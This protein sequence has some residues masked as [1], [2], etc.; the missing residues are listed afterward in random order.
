[1][2]REIH[3]IGIRL[4]FTDRTTIHR[5]GKM[6]SLPSDK[7]FPRNQGTVLHGLYFESANRFLFFGLE[8]R[9]LLQILFLSIKDS[10]IMPSFLK[11]AI[12]FFLQTISSYLD[13][14]NFYGFVSGR[15]FFV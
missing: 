7:L 9:M 5:T 12:N 1:M 2:L 14:G 15:L 11:I 13:S 3:K 8:P 4:L 6:D 10:L